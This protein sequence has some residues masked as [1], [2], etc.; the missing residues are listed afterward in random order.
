MGF[1]KYIAEHFLKVNNNNEETA[2]NAILSSNEAQLHAIPNPNSQNVNGKSSGM[3]G[4]VW[5]RK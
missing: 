2:V 5:G 3:F 1:E 4:K